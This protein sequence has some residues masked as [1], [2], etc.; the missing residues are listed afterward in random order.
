ML[1][2]MSQSAKAV[3]T[4]GA[5]GAVAPQSKLNLQFLVYFKYIGQDKSCLIFKYI[6]ALSSFAPLAK[7]SCVRPCNLRLH[8]PKTCGIGKTVL[9]VSCAR[10]KSHFWKSKPFP[11]F[12]QRN[13]CTCP[14]L[15]RST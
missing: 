12:R 10:F 11:T 9:S 15:S 4:G 6:G 8:M 3:H 14:C 7:K 1:C 2:F 13:I 5:A